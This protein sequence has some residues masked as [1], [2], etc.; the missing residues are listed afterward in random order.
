M[1]GKAH[2]CDAIR[3]NHQQ[4]DDDVDEGQPVGEVGPGDRDPRS[5]EK[6]PHLNPQPAEPSPHQLLL[7][8]SPPP[9]FPSNAPFTTVTLKM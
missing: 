2:R 6:N 9:L 5:A 3:A 8:L 1:L 4:R 7:A